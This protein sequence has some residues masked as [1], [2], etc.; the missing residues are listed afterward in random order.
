[1][2]ADEM[3]IKMAAYRNC[4]G[5]RYH[6]CRRC[7][8]TFDE[9][10]KPL[11]APCQRFHPK[12]NLPESPVTAPL[13][14]VLKKES[15]FEGSGKLMGV[16]TSIPSE[17]QAV[18]LAEKILENYGGLPKDAV[19]LKVEQVSLEQDNIKTET[20]EERYPQF[21]QVIDEQ[22]INGAP[23]IGPG[24]EIN[25]CLGENGEIL[26]IEKAWHHVEP[27]GEIPVISVTEAYEKLQKR[28]LLVVPQSSLEG[29]RISDLKTRLFC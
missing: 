8:G 21:T 17:E 6:Q 29:V 1:M 11:Q 9:Y 7:H 2:E 23:V 12:K 3:E 14:H 26:Q 20:G 27:A 22:Q 24:A 25:I 16:K 10:V 18:P 5:M 13:Y 15:M 4:S 19:L 28:D